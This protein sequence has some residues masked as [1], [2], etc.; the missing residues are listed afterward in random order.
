M[1]GPMAAQPKVR[2]VAERREKT[3]L[4][5]VEKPQ[6]LKDVD[7]QE[8]QETD[9]LMEEMFGVLTIHSTVPWLELI[10]NVDSFSQTVEN[11]FTLS[12]LV[13]CSTLFT[14]A[15]LAHVGQSHCLLCMLV[16]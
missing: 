11:I 7:T 14:T 15:C 6:E 5:A 3:K 8:K 9:R 10:M 12:F 1:L 4:A 13:S 16:P 2:K